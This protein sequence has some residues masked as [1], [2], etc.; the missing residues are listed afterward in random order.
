MKNIVALMPFSIAIH[1]KFIHYELTRFNRL[2]I[3]ASNT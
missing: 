1:S 2:D 3:F